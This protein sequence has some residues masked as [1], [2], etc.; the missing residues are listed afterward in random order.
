MRCWYLPNNI[1]NTANVITL[2]YSVVAGVFFTHLITSLIIPWPTI[3]FAAGE[4]FTFGGGWGK[5]VIFGIPA[6]SGLCIAGIYVLFIESIINRW[7]K[8]NFILEKWTKG[9]K[10]E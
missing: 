1:N 4:I 8:N 7:Y 3:Y 10:N 9:S 6:L 5:L 2:L